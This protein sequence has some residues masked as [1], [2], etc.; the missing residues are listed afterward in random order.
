MIVIKHEDTSLTQA[1]TRLTEACAEV[2]SKASTVIYSQE[3]VAVF[4]KNP[5]NI[6]LKQSADLFDELHIKHPKNAYILIAVFY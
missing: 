6:K 5:M 4:Y 3:Q 2:G 1:L